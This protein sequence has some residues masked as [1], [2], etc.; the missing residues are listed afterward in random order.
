MD[1][2][3]NSWKVEDINEIKLREHYIYKDIKPYTKY[4][5]YIQMYVTNMKSGQSAF[6]PYLYFMTDP[7]GECVKLCCYSRLHIG[8]R[9]NVVL[10]TSGQTQR[11]SVLLNIQACSFLDS[12]YFGS[13]AG[14]KI[15]VLKK[16]GFGF[17]F[18]PNFH[19]CSY[20]CMFMT[21]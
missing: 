6:S 13:L 21:K 7:G 3:C 10:L 17:K 16:W 4:V 12:G 14:K 2:L 11:V 15:L 1:C 19:L 20:V 5:A 8:A 9:V 18:W